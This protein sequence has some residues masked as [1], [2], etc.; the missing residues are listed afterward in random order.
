LIGGALTAVYVVALL[1]TVA[2]RGGHTRPLYD[3][4]VPPSSYRFVAPPAFFA[5]NNEKPTSVTTIVPLTA[6]GS[7]AAGIAT[8]DGQFVVDLAAGAIPTRAGAT[9]AKVTITPVSPH[10]VPAFTPPLRGNGNVYRVA[11]TYEPGGAS[12]GVLRAPGSL[13]VELPEL[14]THLFHD[15]Q[16]QAWR[17]LPARTIGPRQL[18]L[19]S[20]FVG[21]GD[22]LA[23]TTLPELVTGSAKSSHG[24]LVVASVTTVIA[25]ALLIAV[26]FI[27]RRRRRA[28]A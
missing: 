14:G 24:A 21:S 26:V 23:A 5:A 16:S 7:R 10:A 19:T 18:T 17:E 20:D 4:F 15:N 11:M 1:G 12:V 8:P 22:Y 2:L 9:S 28:A 25:I 3:G 6:Q 13:L 27:V